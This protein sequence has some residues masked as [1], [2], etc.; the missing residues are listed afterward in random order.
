M[1]VTGHSRE[2]GKRQLRLNARKSFAHG[3]PV[4]VPANA[5]RHFVGMAAPPTFALSADQAFRGFGLIGAVYD[6]SNTGFISVF[7]GNLQITSSPSAIWC[8]PPTY[9]NSNPVG[10]A[11]LR[12]ATGRKTPLYF[13]SDY[14]EFGMLLGP[15]LLDVMA[16]VSNSDVA[17]HNVNL[18]CA[19]IIEIYDVV[20]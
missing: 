13:Q 3:E 19:G 12:L 4:S 6:V 8:I 16:D 15:I 7:G 10:V 17:A 14:A 1:G 2:G 11:G 9:T 20:R 5:V 18:F